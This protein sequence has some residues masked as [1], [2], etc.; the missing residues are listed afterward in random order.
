[1]ARFEDS[2]EPEVL[3]VMPLPT[4]QQRSYEIMLARVMLVRLTSSLQAITW[5]GDASGDAMTRY[6]S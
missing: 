3:A 1:M 5:A 6:K 2:V 4:P